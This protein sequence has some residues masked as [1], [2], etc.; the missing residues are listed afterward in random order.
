MTQQ[1]IYAPSFVASLFDD[2]ARTYGVVNL[3]S[4]F[5]FARRWRRQCLNS[6][7]I[8]H[9]SAVLDLMTGMGELCPDLLRTVGPDGKVRAVDISPE[10]CNRARQHVPKNEPRLQVIEADALQCPIEDGSVDY[11]VS[12]FGLKTFNPMQL[13]KL[14][15][16]VARVL[17]PGGQFAFL[18][19]SVPHAR[20]LSWPYMFYLNRLI[21]LIGRLAFGNPDNYRLLGVYT[22]A[23]KNCKSVADCFA[24]AELSV[25]YRSYF[26]GCATGIAGSKP[27]P[28]AG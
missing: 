21:P 3:I 28:E 8:S 17:R 26:F 15:R 18:E 1:D 23:F 9:G 20:V 25:D 4:S 24:S 14:A 7:H 5:G 6:I 11:V 19:I 12:T 27:N 2:M 10:M 13:D 22:S 16:E